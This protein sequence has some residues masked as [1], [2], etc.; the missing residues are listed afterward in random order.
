[1]NRGKKRLNRVK[2]KIKFINR[3]KVKEIVET[4][5][6]T[7]HIKPETWCRFRLTHRNTR[8][9]IFQNF[10]SDFHLNINSLTCEAAVPQAGV[11]PTQ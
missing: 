3:Y 8:D 2:R 7:Q 9:S 10:T 6:G 4:Q 5:E 11:L 1:M